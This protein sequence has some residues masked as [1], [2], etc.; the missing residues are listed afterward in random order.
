MEYFGTFSIFLYSIY[1]ALFVQ[2]AYVYVI[3]TQYTT[4]FLS[5]QFGGNADIFC[6]FGFACFD[7]RGDG[8]RCKLWQCGS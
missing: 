8:E 1:E 2:N 5:E 3:F 6:E 7:V 4:A